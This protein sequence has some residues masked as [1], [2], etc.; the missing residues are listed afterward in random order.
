MW[1]VTGMEVVHT[2]CAG[3]DVHK[4]TVT[5]C[6]MTPGSTGEGRS[7]TR[8]FTTMTRDLLALSDWLGGNSVS[9]VGM[10]STGEYW[11]PVYNVLEGRFEVVLANAGQM[12]DMTTT[13]RTRSGLPSCCASG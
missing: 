7:E 2:H 6:C 4:K 11:K 3:L 8:T 13:S 12:K 5:A 9:H 10:E 1:Q